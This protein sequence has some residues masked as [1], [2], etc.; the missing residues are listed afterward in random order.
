MINKIKQLAESAF[1]EVVEIRRHIHKNPELSFKEY[2]TSA[3][4]KS[5]LISWDISFT[6]DI[7]DTGIVV[8]LEG[9]NPSSKTI[10]LRAD[11]DAL[12]ITEENDID[13]C[14]VNKG[15]MHACV[16]DVHTSSLLGAIKILQSLKSEFIIYFFT[17]KTDISYVKRRLK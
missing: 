2:K 17:L 11:F 13:Y 16:H 1:D 5:V 9:N 12:P 15:V 7:A 14:S 3:Y 10:A 8:L 6:E 4:I